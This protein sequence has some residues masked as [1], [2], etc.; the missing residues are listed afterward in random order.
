MK[1]RTKI[2]TVTFF[3]ILFVQGINCFLEIGFLFNNFEKKSI[4][5]YK[6]IGNEIKRTLDKSL[7]FGKPLTDINYKRLLTKKIPSNVQDLFILDNDGKNIYSAK[8]SGYKKSFKVYQ[9]YTQFKTPDYYKIFIPLSDKS[10]VKGNLLI[11]VPNKKIKKRLFYLIKKS[12]ITFLIIVTS[13]LPVLFGLLTIFINT[14]Y[15]KFI[16]NLESWIVQ[17][18]YDKLK[19]NRIDLT[20]IFNAEKKIKKIKRGEWLS[21]NH[22]SLYEPFD[23]ITEA[24]DRASYKKNIFTKFMRLLNTN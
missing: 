11:I 17:E 24:S 6:I 3:I 9:S 8:H 22:E 18:E 5:K 13:T 19:E 10:E 12:L 15:N 7:T 20:P 16:N 14:P 21:T 1:L 2:L 23:Y 4:N